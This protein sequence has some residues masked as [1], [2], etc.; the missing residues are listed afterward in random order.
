MTFYSSD[1]NDQEEEVIEFDDIRKTQN[2]PS[3]G[4]EP[5]DDRYS[6]GRDSYSKLKLSNKL[7]SPASFENKSSECALL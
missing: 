6:T 7:A 1:I 5:Y 4:S 2:F 3:H